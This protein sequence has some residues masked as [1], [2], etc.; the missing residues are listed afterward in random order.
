MSIIDELAEQKILAAIAAGE[1]DN[2]PNKGKPLVLDDDSM[3]PEHLRVGYRVLKNAGFV[4]PELEWSRQLR[5]VEDLIEQLGDCDD[6]PVMDA[7]AEKRLKLLQSRLRSAGTQR[8]PAWVEEPG[9]RQR[10][11]DRLSR[12]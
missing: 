1:L 7:L 8:R 2:L 4:P 11:L 6:A 3:I 9:Y 12:R 10:I 5:D